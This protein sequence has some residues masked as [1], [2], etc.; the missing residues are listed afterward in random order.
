MSDA[1]AIEVCFDSYYNLSKLCYEDGPHHVYWLSWNFLGKTYK[2]DE[3]AKQSSGPSM[4]KNVVKFAVDNITDNLVPSEVLNAFPFRIFLCTHQA[5][6]AVANVNPFRMDTVDREN[7][8]SLLPFQIS[9]WVEF[10]PISATGVNPDYF[11]DGQSSSVKVSIR[12]MNDSDEDEAYVDDIFEVAAEEVEQGVHFAETPAPIAPPAQKEEDKEEDKVLHHYRLSVDMRTIG[13]LKRPAHVSLNYLYPFLGTSTPVRTKPAWVVAHAETRVDNGAAS[14]ECAMSPE[15]LRST[16]V[17][18]PLKIT[19]LSR[20]HLGNNLLGELRVD[21]AAVTYVDPHSFRCPLTGKTFRALKDYHKHRQILLALLAAGRVEQA[22]PRD[23]IT[24]RA[25]DT[26]LV[27]TSPSPESKADAAEG[28]GK[29]VPNYIVPLAE[30]GKLRLVLILEDFGGVGFESAVRVKPGYKMHNGALYDNY[31]VG[32]GVP[33]AITAEDLMHGDGDVYGA[34]GGDVLA[35]AAARNMHVDPSERT[36]LSPAQRATLERLKIDWEAWRRT[37]DVQ[38]RDAMMQKEVLMRNR[39]EVEAAAKLVDRADDLKRAHVETGKLEVRLR[40]SIGEVER[41]RAQLKLKEEQMQMRLAQKTSELQLLQRRV[42]D[43]AKGMV[44]NEA[45][46]SEGLQQ[47]IVSLQESFR[48]MEKRAKDA[49]HDFD[50]YRAQLRS[51]PESVLREETARLRAVL[52]E[53]RGEVERER[54]L[55]SECELEKEHFRSQMHRLALALKRERER[56]STIARQEM[57]QLRLEF[58]AREERYVLDGDR[59]ELRCIRAELSG[60]RQSRAGV[61]G[62]R[63][64][65]DRGGG[66]REAASEEKRDSTEGLFGYGSG[67]SGVPSSSACLGDMLLQH[68]RSES[69]STTSGSAAL[70]ADQAVRGIKQQ[71]RE[72]L[73]TG[74]YSDQGDPVVAELRQNLAAAEQRFARMRA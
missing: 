30:G 15:Q 32:Q 65:A 16:L 51:S 72:L 71:I 68:Q 69:A 64:G 57:E 13:G 49:E 41:Q 14:Y 53:S 26:Y 66:M 54:R 44:H 55:R 28:G 23:P 39:L 70:E 24:V 10:S 12:V 31:G 48:L 22:P 59:E 61:G 34:D 7:T 4:L 9:E 19:A 27:F 3:F 73:D 1:V 74:L 11:K 67:G 43:E 50:H 60:L 47:T 36:D 42:R 29:A 17:E 37:V 52:G 58:M 2:S 45:R 21:L 8:T 40:G 38:W 18:H 25:L 20:S 62:D 35:E 46:K 63:V 33:G 56:S 6:L 5:I